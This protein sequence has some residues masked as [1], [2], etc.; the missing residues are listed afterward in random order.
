ME[1][2]VRQG[3]WWWLIAVP[4]VAGVFALLGGW[5]GSRLGKDTEHSQWQRNERM[6]A[7]ADF[8]SA[9][10]EARE[11]IG[12]LE[13]PPSLME[14]FPNNELARIE[15]VGSQA[16]RV[17]ASQFRS[18][19]LR[20][21]MASMSTVEAFGN[22]D[23]TEAERVSQVNEYGSFAEQFAKHRLA[24]V[25]AVRK[26]LGTYSRGDGRANGIDSERLALARHL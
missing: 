9:I 15:I 23:L 26:D 13:H 4:V 5:W 6:K 3:Q 14:P 19:L 22:A 24:F 2:L 20:V 7:Y 18:C 10:D 11:K 1:E 21:H 8:L 12:P 16:V 25:T 17:L